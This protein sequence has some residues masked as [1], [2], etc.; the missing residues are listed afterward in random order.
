MKFYVWNYSSTFRK[1][2]VSLYRFHFVPKP[3]KLYP[4]RYHL[5]LYLDGCI[6]TQHTK[7]YPKTNGGYKNKGNQPTDQNVHV[8]IAMKTWEFIN[9]NNGS[10]IPKTWRKSNQAYKILQ[11]PETRQFCHTLHQLGNAVTHYSVQLQHPGKSSEFVSKTDSPHHQLLDTQIGYSLLNRKIN[12]A[13]HR[14]PT[15]NYVD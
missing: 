11:K 13:L 4:E 9:W 5:L 2:I 6:Q 8:H 15:E 12:T 1:T 10:V 14:T 3:Q 7:N